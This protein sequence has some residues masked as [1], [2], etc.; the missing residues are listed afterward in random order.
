MT[1]R[2]LPRIT[3][4]RK[5]SCAASVRIWSVRVAVADRGA[6]SAIPRHFIQP[7]VHWPNANPL[8]VT[9][10][11]ALVDEDD[12]AGLCFTSTSNF[13]LELFERRICGDPAETL[14]LRDQM[15]QNR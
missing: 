8:T 4:P 13:T 14:G 1:S 9:N 11:S 10:H 5:C 3:V 2:S 6:R 15:A 7:S 12:L